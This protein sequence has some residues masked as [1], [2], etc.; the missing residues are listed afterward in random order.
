MHSS[1]KLLWLFLGQLVV[2]SSAA[3]P[4]AT[5]SQASVTLEAVT[6]SQAQRDGIDVQAGS[7]SLRITALRDDIVRVRIAPGSMFPEDSSWAVLPE[8]AQQVRRLCNAP[9]GRGFRRLS[10]RGA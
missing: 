8:A 10:H 2:L 4:S 5:T 1:C 3:A 6:S 9:A 7:A